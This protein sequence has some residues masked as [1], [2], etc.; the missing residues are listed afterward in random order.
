VQA[1]RGK[2]FGA[3][4]MPDIGGNTATTGGQVGCHDAAH[5]TEPNK[6]NATLDRLATVTRPN[7]S[8]V[9]RR[10]GHRSRIDVLPLHS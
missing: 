1:E 3:I 5:T 7:W 10:A 4:R 9:R 8:I 6:P 2:L